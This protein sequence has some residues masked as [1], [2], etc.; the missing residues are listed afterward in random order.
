MRKVTKPKVVCEHCGS[1]LKH[2]QYDAFCDYCQQ[3]IKQDNSENQIEIIVFWKSD[4][5]ARSQEFCSM[6]CARRWLLNFPWNKKRVNFINLP[7]A[8][9]NNIVEFLQDKKET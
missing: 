7:Y 1:I 3:K 8:T 5:N 6:K 4:S 2:E 9:M